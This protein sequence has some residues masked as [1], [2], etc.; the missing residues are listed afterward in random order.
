[1]RKKILPRWCKDV[2]KELIEKDMDN[3]DLADHCGV[4][5]SFICA[6][7]NGRATSDTVVVKISKLLN[8]QAPEGSIVFTEE[9]EKE[10]H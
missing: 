9:K 7:V 6:V 2:Q 8:V 3:Q 5:R 10:N 1:M 4:T